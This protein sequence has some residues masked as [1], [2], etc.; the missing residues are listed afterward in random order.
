MFNIKFSALF[1]LTLASIAIAGPVVGPGSD[2]VTTYIQ[3]WMLTFINRKVDL[4][5][6]WGRAEV[7]KRGDDS[8]DLSNNWVRAELLTLSSSKVDS[9]NI[10]KR[11]DDSVDLSNNWGR[12]EQQHFLG[13]WGDI[14]VFLQLEPLT[15][16]FSKVGKRGEDSVDLSNN[17]GRAV[18][19]LFEPQFSDVAFGSVRDL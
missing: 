5:N 8:V 7:G 17:W 19:S 13:T 3:L 1:S 9:S 12:A 14:N 2:S 15:L 11:G 18:E 6:N 16:N 4:S 10:G